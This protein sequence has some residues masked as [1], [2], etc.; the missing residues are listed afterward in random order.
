MSADKNDNPA[1][2]TIAVPALAPAP[3]VDDEGTVVVP[4]FDL[5]FSFFA[6]SQA[7][8]SFVRRLRSPMPIVPDIVKMR[9]ITDERLVPQIKAARSLYPC[10]S[11]KS[12]MDGIPVETFVPEGGV[13][14]E[15]K[16]R[17]LINLHGGGFV[18]G[19]GGPGGA[20]ESIPVAGLGRIKVV[21]VDYRLAPEHPF[22]APN[23]D[24]AIVYRKLLK[25]YRPENIGLYGC[26]A[27]GVLTGQ[28]V[29]WFLKEKLPL[30]GA[31]GI[32]CASIHGF[33][34]G[35]SAYLQPRLGSV[36]RI[37][38]T[39]K[40]NLSDDPLVRPSASMEVMK[41]F[42][43]TLFLTG[44]RA[45]EMS[46][47]CQ[48]HLELRELGVKSDLLLFDGLDHGFYSDVSLPESLVANKLIVRFFEENLGV[49][50]G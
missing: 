3:P 2:A 45:P 19:G 16:D 34:C 43:P 32:F 20:I 9:A 47:S 38:R 24:L 12:E 28:A 31:I 5:P 15:N 42:P 23:E 22:P 36:L 46:G 27:G 33:E 4:S 29:P 40:P 37:I 35:D 50:S 26:S 18:A 44:T 10:R 41:A 8:E 21:A 30:P 48:G 25:F 14:P 1:P 13:T 11:A 49:K 7:R 6:S 17:V 39:E